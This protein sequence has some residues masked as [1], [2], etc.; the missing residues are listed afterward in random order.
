[1][2]A[3]NL[4]DAENSGFGLL[5][6]AFVTERVNIAVHAYAIAQRCLELTLDHVRLRESFGKPLIARAG[7]GGGAP[8]P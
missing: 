3:A 2:P 5:G 7:V 8:L 4:V 1:M 6:A